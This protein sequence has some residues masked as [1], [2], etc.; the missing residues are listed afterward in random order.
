ML[1][2]P[3]DLVAQAAAPTSGTICRAILSDAA[4]PKRAA[5]PRDSET[6]SG[7]DCFATPRS[8]KCWLISE[9]WKASAKRR[10]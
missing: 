6:M 1:V 4:T 2:N 3:A 10:L 7:T 8:T 5:I 9:K